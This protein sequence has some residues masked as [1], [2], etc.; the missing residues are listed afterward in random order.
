M[1]KQTEEIPDL[2]S[3]K[4][5]LDLAYDELKKIKGIY[6]ITN[7]KNNKL[8]IGSSK[9]IYQRKQEHFRNLEQNKHTNPRLQNAYN[10]YGKEN[11]VFEVLEILKGS[12]DQFIVEDKYIK[13]LEAYNPKIGYNINIGT[14]E[15]KISEETRQKISK[16]NARYFLG[17]K[18]NNKTKKKMSEAKKSFK[19]PVICL[20]TGI[21]YESVHEA[22]RKT[23]IKVNYL[24]RVLKKTRNHVFGTHWEYINKESTKNP[25]YIC[26]KHKK[27]IC[28]ET[29]NIYKTIT[30]ASK[31]IG[32]HRS[33]IS[34]CCKGERITAGGYHWMFYEEYLIKC[35]DKNN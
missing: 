15:I 35:I 34:K 19:K 28:I 6:K 29:K 13:S 7:I 33:D 17:K 26:T 16:N 4:Y 5:R 21:E 12:E 25:D 2:L 14:Q 20:D 1:S 22:S 9:D 31:D 18:L 11:F 32:I 10:Y 23:G 27:V 24:T 30:Q 3:K 8:Y